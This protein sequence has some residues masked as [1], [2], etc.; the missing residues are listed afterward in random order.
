MI[1]DN[2][3]PFGLILLGQPATKKN[4]ATITKMGKKQVPSLIP[5]KALLSRHG[6]SSKAGRAG[7]T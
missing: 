7:L 3:K 5:S 6:T 4:S 2:T 1:G